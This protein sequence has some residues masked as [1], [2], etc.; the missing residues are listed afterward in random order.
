MEYAAMLSMKQPVAACRRARE[1]QCAGGRR[2]SGRRWVGAATPMNRFPLLLLGAASGVA[3]A[4]ST[5]RGAAGRAPRRP[6]P[7][8]WRPAPPPVEDP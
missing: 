5:A 4:P 1:Q 2:T 7:T 3:G 6:W 8:P